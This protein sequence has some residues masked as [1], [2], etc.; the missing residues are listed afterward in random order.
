MRRTVKCPHCGEPID[1]YAT[2]EG[3]EVMPE[4]MQPSC[5]CEITE[6]EEKALWAKVGVK[7]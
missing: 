5:D 1:L 3:G 4:D 2:K 6:E 7:E